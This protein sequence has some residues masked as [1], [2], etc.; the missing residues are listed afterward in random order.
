MVKSPEPHRNLHHGPFL[1]CPECFKLMQG[2]KDFFKLFYFNLN[3]LLKLCFANPYNK[4]L[5][6][7]YCKAEPLWALCHGKYWGPAQWN[8]V[9]FLENIDQYIFVRV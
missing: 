4:V 5:I 7:D 2:R 3:S 8:S 1:F 9:V 6:I